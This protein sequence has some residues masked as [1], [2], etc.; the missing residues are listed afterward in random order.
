VR[1]AVAYRRGHIPGAQLRDVVIT[2][3]REPLS[4]VIDK[5]AEVVFYCYGKYCPMLAFASAKALKW[6]SRR[7]TTLP[8]GTL[9]GR[10]M[11][12]RWR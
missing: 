4:E 11:A 7:C 5:D 8:V 12:T 3:S 10:T 6:V 9:P 2:L 1:F